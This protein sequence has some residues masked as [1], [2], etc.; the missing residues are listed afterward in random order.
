MH[1]LGCLVA[2]KT[3]KVVRVHRSARQV[4]AAAAALL[5][6]GASATA[7]EGFATAIT[8]LTGGRRVRIV[9]A[10]DTSSAATDFHCNN[11]NAQLA[12]YDTA[13]DTVRIIRSTIDSYGRP[14]ITRNGSRVVYSDRP[15]KKVRIIDWSGAN[16]RTIADGFAGCVWHD[17]VA[18]KDYVYYQLNGDGHNSSNPVHRRNVDATGEDMLIWNGSDTNLTWAAISSDGARIAGSWPWSK[19]GVIEPDY[20][21]SGGGTAY[22]SGN[23]YY[24]NGCWTGITPDTTHRAC[25]FDGAHKNWRVFSTPTSGEFLLNLNQAVGIEAYW[26]VYHPRFTNDPRFM[27]LT[28]P[29]SI[30]SPNANNIGR[31][32]RQVEVFFCKLS[33]DLTSITGYVKLAYSGCG[34]AADFYPDAW[35]DPGSSPPPSPPGVS[36][37]AA[38]NVTESGARLRGEVTS[39]GGE[40]PTVR[41]YWGTSNGGTNAGD[42]DHEE[43][44][45]ARG[46]GVFT[47]DTSGLAPDTTYYFRCH[48]ANSGGATCASGTQSFTTEQIQLRD[49]ENPGGVVA[50]GINVDYYA[51]S[52]LSALPDFETL[53]PYASDVVSEINFGSSGGFATSGRATDVGAVFSGYIN[54][55]NDGVYTFYTESDDGSALYIGS[56][57]VVDNDGN[58]GMT[59]KSGTIGLKAG[60]HAITVEFYQGGGGYGLVARYSGPGIGKTVIPSSAF[61]Y[62]PPAVVAPTVVTNDASLVSSNSARL[63]G[64]LTATGGE[65]PSISFVWGDDDAGTGSWDHTLTVGVQG[66]GAFYEDIS[67]LATSTTYYFRA[68]AVNG[69]GTAWGEVKVFTTSAAQQ[70]PTITSQPADASVVDGNTASFTVAATGSSPLSYQWQRDDGAGWNN[71]GPDSASYTT[72]ATTLGDDG[73]LFRCI[74]S[75]GISPDATSNVATLTVTDGS[76]GLP[77]QIDCGTSSAVP[78][79]VSGN[80][81]ALSGANFS[82]GTPPDTTGV[83]N[84]APAAVYPTVRHQSPQYSIPEIPDGNCTLRLHFY[85]DWDG[86]DDR[87]FTVAAEGVDL[88]TNFSI[89]VAAG[90][91]GIPVA[92][93]FDVTVGGGDGLQIVLDQAGG[94]DAFLSGI[95]V[96]QPS[97]GTAPA[98]TTQPADA[99]VAEGYTATFTVAATGSSPLSYQWQ[100]DDG[101]GWNNVGTDSASYM[102]PATTLGD[103]GA[104]FRCIVSNGVSPDAT[105]DTALLTVAGTAPAITTQPSNATV[106]E[107]NAATFTVA[108]TGSSPLSYQWQRDD[109]AGWNNVGTDSASYT[110]PATTLSDD[111]ALFRCIVSNGVSP[112][113][114]SDV[115]TL[116][117]AGGAQTLTVLYPTGGAFYGSQ[118][119]TIIWNSSFSGGVTIEFTEDGWSS[120]VVVEASTPNDGSHTWQ[121][122]NTDAADCAFRVL[123][124][125]DGAPSDDSGTFSIQEIADADGDRLD[126]LWETDHF[127]DTDVTDGGTT[128]TDGDGTTDV[129]EF[130][131]GSDPNELIT[132]FGVTPFSCASDGDSTA[133]GL[134]SAA[135]MLLLGY[136]LLRRKQWGRS[137]RQEAHDAGRSGGR[138]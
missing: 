49:P 27:V 86:V 124:A 51:V 78:G 15:E 102:T 44:L 45:G 3:A 98:I 105:S 24:T 79:W 64:E 134:A 55:P 106:S 59:E 68:R 71:V 126:D 54:V 115:A 137:A 31:G 97:T 110:T 40:N 14:L 99:S 95:E 60:T 89:K 41:I 10:Q 34:D 48:A 42:W 90:G 61:H 63:N 113:A 67:A 129:E 84:A 83:A 133:K 21:G 12:S 29:Y 136:G 104:Q 100:R 72:P 62:V 93:D 58:H 88:L 47:R 138:W 123:D 91:K 109:G 107:G 76:I 32:G 39:T 121:L 85:D 19:C 25:V 66:T 33:A 118:D 57:K 13:D 5:T 65:D 46:T 22:H 135:I 69:G 1:Q 131:A 111:G 80:I 9:W 81:Y 87:S 92:L 18:G 128:D 94:S 73:A 37:L 53:T 50:G 28:G 20:G 127:G 6:F 2:G 43:N 70:A 74:V 56:S 103:D 26:E 30:G 8:S 16:L 82:F 38:T 108:A 96:L 35:V 120:S 36:T 112:D 117:V 116:T 75:N 7:G 4:I 17:D 101:A 52:G 130:W 119:V 125:S 77:L 23:G 122:P 114:T 11:N 132:V